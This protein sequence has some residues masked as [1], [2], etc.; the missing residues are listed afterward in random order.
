MTSLGDPN[1]RNAVRMLLNAL[2]N[3][4]DDG[5]SHI[6]VSIK[7]TA[8]TATKDRIVG[9]ADAAGAH[10]PQRPRMTEASSRYGP[11]GAARSRWP[12]LGVL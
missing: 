10:E 5:V 2:A 11:A 1:T 8:T 3:A 12:R 7:I 6:Q 4:V 9:R